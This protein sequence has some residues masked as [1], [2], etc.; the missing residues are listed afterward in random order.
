MAGNGV[1]SPKEYGIG[2]DYVDLLPSGEADIPAIQKR[3]TPKTTVVAI[4]RSRGYATRA[5]FTVAKIKAMIDAVRAVAPD[6]TV[7]VDNA[8]GEF[9]ETV[10]PLQVGA[11]LMAGS[12]FKNAG[13]GMAKTGGISLVTLT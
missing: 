3:I 13:G 4:Q 12:L 5:S 8:Y 2:V 10:E 9:S 7:F 1:G 11:N 6:I